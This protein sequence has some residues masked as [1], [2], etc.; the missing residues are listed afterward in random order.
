MRLWVAFREVAARQAASFSASGVDLSL[1]NTISRTFQGIISGGGGI[2]T[3]GSGGTTILTNANTFTGPATINS[4]TTLEIGNGVSNNASVAG[5]IVDNGTLILNQNPSGNNATF[6][7]P[8]SG[9]GAVTIATTSPLELPTA[10]TYS[11]GTTMTVNGEVDLTNTTG[12]ALG[13][14]AV[15]VGSSTP[16][17]P[18]S[19]MLLSGSAAYAGQLNL[20][21]GGV[22][23]PAVVN[24]STTTITPGTLAGGSNGVIAGNSALVFVINNAN[25]TL[26]TNWDQITFSGSLSLTATPSA[27]VYLSIS[28]LNASFQA[29]QA[30]NFDP[31]QSYSWQ[32]VSAAG[33]I[34]GFDA[35]SFNL[36]T[37]AISNGPPGFA[38]SMGAGS[39]FC[40]RIGQRSFRQLYAGP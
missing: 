3:I 34:T 37:A 25:G 33:G 30:L 20:T 11:G 19:G 14:G 7:N 13:T 15:T 27:P 36:S 12:S 21:G 2:S 17:T 28:S 38:N 31:T 29:G 4:G 10:N 26:G 32:F 39:F 5:S 35:S 6:S 9:T 23:L 16:T 24:Q 1:A 22:L 18:Y 40:F 8:I